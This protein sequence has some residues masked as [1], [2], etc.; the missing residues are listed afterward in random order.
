MS[1]PSS[2]A[3]AVDSYDTTAV[4]RLRPLSYHGLV[5]FAGNCLRP[6]FL[7]GNEIEDRER[8]RR[9]DTNGGSARRMGAGEG[10][11]VKNTPLGSS[12]ECHISSRVR[13][14]AHLDACRHLG[15]DSIAMSAFCE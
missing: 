7:G 2:A 9:G 12:V 10:G 1:E 13:S 6:D 11:S 8:W 15:L 14:R 5:Q 3:T 4:L